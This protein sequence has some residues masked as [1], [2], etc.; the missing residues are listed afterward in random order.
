MV[1]KVEEFFRL[2]QAEARVDLHHAAH[3]LE[4]LPEDVREEGANI[5]STTCGASVQRRVFDV[6]ENTVVDA[7]GHLECQRVLGFLSQY[8]VTPYTYDISPL[9][10]RG[11]RP[12]PA[13]LVD[14]VK[15][16]Y[17]ATVNLCAETP[18]GDIP[19]IRKAGLTGLS[20][21]HIPIVDGTPPSP[22]QVIQLLDLLAEL[23]GNGIRTYLHCEAGKART[24]VMTA[25][26][27]MAVMGWSV[28]DALT[29]AKNFGCSIPMQQAFI[30]DFWT[31][32][33]AQYKARAD[34]SPLPYPALSRYPL[35]PPGA[36]KATPQQLSATLA[37]VAQSG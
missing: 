17:A 8:P 33:E 23:A 24:G 20:G 31:K 35:L 25:C 27:R 32:L 19:N 13:K 12:S 26:V 6:L 3:A 16:G 4:D 18:D 11:Q 1:D 9:L 2:R 36:V 29:E 30:E 7:Y 14:L 21:Y 5:L 37:G 28:Q 34:N 15:K 10:S 22:D